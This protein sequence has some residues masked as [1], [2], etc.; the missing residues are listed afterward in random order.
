MVLHNS[1]CV[2]HYTPPSF[3]HRPILRLRSFVRYVLLGTLS[4]A[5]WM[6]LN[7]IWNL[8][9][10]GMAIKLLSVPAMISQWPTSECVHGGIR[11]RSIGYMYFRAVVRAGVRIR[12]TREDFS[13]YKAYG[14]VTLEV[15]TI[16]RLYWWGSTCRARQNRVVRLQDFKC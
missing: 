11:G 3:A 5:A 1:M 7:W 4:P 6:V 13:I 10:V 15:L 16:R 2:Q 8:S 9:Q 12:G 14:F